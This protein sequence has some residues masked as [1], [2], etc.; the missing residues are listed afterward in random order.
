MKKNSFLILA[1]FLFWIQLTM[2]SQTTVQG[3]QSSNLLEFLGWNNQGFSK[4]LDIRNDFNAAI[5]FFITPG[6]TPNMSLSPTGFLGI[7][8]T[9]PSMPLHV[10]ASPLLANAQGWRRGIMLS[11]L[12]TLLWEGQN[13]NNFF[14]AHS[15]TNP[16]ANFFE[17]RSTGVGQTAPVDYSRQVFVTTSPN[18]NVP[19]MSTQIF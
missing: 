4:P 10:I 13:G 8:T 11:D 14:M 3:N 18:A 15:S 12:S 1:C 7:G 17:G 2:L 5:N 9:A 6:P 19:L 16:T